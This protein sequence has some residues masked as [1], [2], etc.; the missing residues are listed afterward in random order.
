MLRLISAPKTVQL[1][2]AKTIFLRF[3]S[4]N[5]NFQR[6]IL[7]SIARLGMLLTCVSYNGIWCAVLCLNY[8]T[9]ILIIT[10]LLFPIHLHGYEKIHYFNYFNN[11]FK[12]TLSKNYLFYHYFF[13]PTHTLCNFPFPSEAK[14][15]IKILIYL[16][17]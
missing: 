2:W 3:S 5:F 11:Y 6:H 1:C 8:L 9:P 10:S 13:F 17:E 7:R 4:S 12:N 16:N 15:I 14:L